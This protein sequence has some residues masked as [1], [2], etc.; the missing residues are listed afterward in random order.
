M[1]VSSPYWDPAQ[2]IAHPSELR[3]INFIEQSFENPISIH[4]ITSPFPS[5]SHNLSLGLSVPANSNLPVG[6]KQIEWISS[7]PSLSYKDPKL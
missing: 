7:Y 4:C 3:S 5:T 2:A 1:Y 6:E